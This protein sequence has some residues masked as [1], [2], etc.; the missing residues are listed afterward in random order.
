MIRSGVFIF[1][2]EHVLHLVSLL[3]IKFKQVCQLGWVQKK[4]PRGVPENKCFEKIR[5]LS[6]EAVLRKCFC[7]QE[8]LK[9]RTFIKITL[10]HGCPPVNTSGENC[11]RLKKIYT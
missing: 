7:K 4:P 5:N 8:F 1:K 9:R 11:L 2:F 6:T 3:K 10:Q